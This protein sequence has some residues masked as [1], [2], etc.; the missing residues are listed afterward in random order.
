MDGT[1]VLGT[2]TVS[3]TL[4][5]ITGLN[6][7]IPRNTTR[8]LVVEVSTHAG[9]TAPRFVAVSVVGAGA[10]DARDPEG[11]DVSVTANVNPLPN[12]ARIVTVQTAGTLTAAISPATPVA[13][14]VA[15][16]NVGVRNVAVTTVRYTAV[17][18]PIILEEI[19]VSTTAVGENFTSVEIFDGTTVIASMPMPAGVNP[20]AVFTG[21]NIEIPTTGHR[22]LVFR[23][24]LNS[25]GNGATSGHIVELD[26]DVI[27]A[28]G[29]NSGTPVPDTANIIGG[30]ALTIRQSVPT[31]A[32]LANQTV[33]TNAND[34]VLRFTVAAD[35]RGDVEL[36]TL[37]ATFNRVL[38]TTEARTIRLFEGATEIATASVT[39]GTTTGTFSITGRTERFIAAGAS[40]TFTVRADS[41]GTAALF[42][43]IRTDAMDGAVGNLVWRDG[44]ATAT[45]INGHLVP[46]LPVT[47]DTLRQ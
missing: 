7:R 27:R 29:R 31:V 44:S 45:D 19:T 17:R 18:E 14:L 28:R 23:A 32:K 10:I 11:L 41:Y 34:E 21:L 22:D 3:G 9:L 33:L 6:L 35:S 39:A 15:V 5:R 37:I 38:H 16:G 36:R 2:A 46:G 25:I 40:R 43:E 12:P 4:A 47:G 26:V 42:A 8:N 20:N 1:T 24:N 30:N 13:G